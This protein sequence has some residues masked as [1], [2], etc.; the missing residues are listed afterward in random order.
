MM[1]HHKVDERPQR[2][3][4]VVNIPIEDSFNVTKFNK[5]AKATWPFRQVNS[6]LVWGMQEMGRKSITKPRVH[7]RLTYLVNNS[8][9]WGCYPVRDEG[10]DFLNITLPEYGRVKIELR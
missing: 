4:A 1:G 3:E 5:K 7:N 2:R 8:C 10:T 6:N 9:K